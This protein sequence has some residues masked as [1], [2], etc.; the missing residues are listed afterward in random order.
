MPRQLKAELFG[1][2]TEDLETSN[3]SD[4]EEVV[5]EFGRVQYRLGR[6]ETD[7]KQTEKEYNQL[8]KRKE[9]LSK[10]IAEFFKNH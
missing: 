1:I 4:I 9:K 3:P 8:T 6:L 2:E 5:F 7:G 10:I